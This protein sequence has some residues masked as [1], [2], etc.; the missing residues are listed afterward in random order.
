MRVVL[1]YS[2]YSSRSSLT[3][4]SEVLEGLADLNL[5]ATNR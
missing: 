4:E 3:I 5:T 1:I 2:Y